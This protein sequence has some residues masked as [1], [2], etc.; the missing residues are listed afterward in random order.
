MLLLVL[1]TVL[2]NAIIFAVALALVVLAIAPF[3]CRRP[4]GIARRQQK[5]EMAGGDDW[6]AKI[7]DDDVDD[8]DDD[9]EEEDDDM[10]NK[11]Q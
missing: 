7:F 3:C 5:A 8:D 4:A 2:I 6:Y 10:Y 11:M 9:E 1:S